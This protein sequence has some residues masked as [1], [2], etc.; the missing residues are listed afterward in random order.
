M[1]GYDKQKVSD[2]GIKPRF[3][4]KDGQWLCVKC[5]KELLLH[6]KKDGDTVVMEAANDKKFDK[7]AA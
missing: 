1:E 3:R 2:C 4:L 5:S 6:F 7:D